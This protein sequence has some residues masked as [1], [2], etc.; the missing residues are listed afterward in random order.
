MRGTN[1]ESLSFISRIQIEFQSQI[2]RFALICTFHSS[3]F[4]VQ[5]LSLASRSVCCSLQSQFGYGS[6]NGMIIVI[7][8]KWLGVFFSAIILMHLLYV[9]V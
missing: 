3:G 2:C 5:N 1:I 7:C 8:G 6:P 9:L 4:V